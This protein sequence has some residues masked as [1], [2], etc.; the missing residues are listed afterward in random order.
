MRLAVAAVALITLTATGDEIPAHILNLARIKR[1]MP[2]ELNPLP[3]YTCLETMDRYVAAHRGKM[4]PIDRIRIQVAIVD[5][6][7]LYSWPGARP[8]ED[9]SLGDMV[10]SG[11]IS[12]GDFVAMA[13]NVFVHGTA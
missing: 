5:D 6:K 4:K 8:F 7:E 9:S 13:R 11:F 10:N 12:D 3:N 1:R 2:E